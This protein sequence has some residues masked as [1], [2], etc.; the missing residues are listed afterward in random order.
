MT[1]SV[2]AFDAY[3]IPQGQ[4]NTLDDL[5]DVDTAEVKEGDT[6]VF[7]HGRWVPGESSKN[8]VSIQNEQPTDGSELWLD[9]DEEAAP[10]P[11]TG[12]TDH[13]A[14]TGLEDDDHPQYLKTTGGNVSGPLTVTTIEAD[15]PWMSVQKTNQAINASAWAAIIGVSG[16]Q[17]GGFAFGGTHIYVPKSGMYLI[18]VR[19]MCSVAGR[20]IVSWDADQEGQY[21]SLSRY[22]FDERGYTAQSHIGSSRPVWITTSWQPY[23]WCSAAGSV[24][25]YAEAI[26]M[27]KAN[28]A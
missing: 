14:L 28:T 3:G 1:I 24:T 11:E 21:G 22:L 4:R 12:V 10:P 5:S 15:V 9:L 26:Y 17:T 2:G 18:S 8:E 7:R 20:F 19:A 13:G 16:G 23:V 6:L 25:C 27:G